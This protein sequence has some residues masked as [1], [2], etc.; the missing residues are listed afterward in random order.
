MGVYI[1]FSGG[2]YHEQAEARHGRW[3]QIGADTKKD[4]VANSVL[5]CTYDHALRGS[6]VTRVQDTNLI[7]CVSITITHSIKLNY[8]FTAERS[9]VVL[10]LCFLLGF[11]QIGVR[12]LSAK[13]RS[14]HLY[15]IL[16]AVRPVLS[17]PMDLVD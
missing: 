17:R 8:V 1:H 7:T 12:C 2:G 10:V 5:P 13:S 14:E 6:A 11:R 16:F 4:T 3:K 9:L 15:A